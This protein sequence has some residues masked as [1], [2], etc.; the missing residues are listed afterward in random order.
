MTKINKSLQERRKIWT[1]SQ[2]TG[3]GKSRKWKAAK[4]PT[5]VKKK[6]NTHKINVSKKSKRKSKKKKR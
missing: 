6:R 4:G 1:P 5:T 2:Q 3:E